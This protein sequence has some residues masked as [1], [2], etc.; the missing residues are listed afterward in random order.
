MAE[1]RAGFSAYVAARRPLLFRT[2]WVLTSDHHQAE[3][4]VQQ[5]LTR[6]YVAWPKVSQLESVDGYE[7]DLR[8]RTPAS[9]AAGAQSRRGTRPMN[10]IL[11][12]P[13]AMPSVAAVSSTDSPHRCRS[14]S[15]SARRSTPASRSRRSRRRQHPWRLRRPAT[16]DAGA[17]PARHVVRRRRRR[18]PPRRTSDSH[19]RRAPILVRRILRG[20]ATR[21]ARSCASESTPGRSP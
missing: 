2:A 3:D 9:R 11:T 15:T 7:P 20:P 18:A 17:A 1:R 5:V 14:T 4:L 19:A 21:G 12:V 8:R 16:G 6:P 10:D 13:G